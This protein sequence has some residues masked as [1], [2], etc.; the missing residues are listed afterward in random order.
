MT[1]LPVTTEKRKAP[2]LS[3]QVAVLL[4]Q[5]RCYMCGGKLR[6]TGH[7]WDHSIPLALGGKH[8]AANIY[9]LCPDC[10]LCKTRA[11]VAIIAK[12]KRQGGEKG[13]Y[14]RRKRNGSKLKSRGFDKSV[15]RKMNGDIERIEND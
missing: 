2:S 3:I 13:Q 5:A 15:K 12:S 8:E 9:C 10:H 6:E 4:R 7:E 1:R 14:A 11:D